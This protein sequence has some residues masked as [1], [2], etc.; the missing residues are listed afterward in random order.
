MLFSFCSDRNLLFDV[1][2]LQEFEKE[3]CF[4]A[5]TRGT[6]VAYWMRKGF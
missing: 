2:I 3:N 1:S 5:V 4:W 6:R